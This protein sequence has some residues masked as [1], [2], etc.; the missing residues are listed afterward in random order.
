MHQRGL[1][2]FGF[3]FTRPTANGEPGASPGLAYDVEELSEQV[4]A[5][6]E[7]GAID[8]GLKGVVV[9]IVHEVGTPCAPDET[10][11]LAVAE[12]EPTHARRRLEPERHNDGED[13]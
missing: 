5:Q 8:G 7:V 4:W 12:T 3:V 10:R 11:P 2:V 9:A 13:R 1:R 6:E